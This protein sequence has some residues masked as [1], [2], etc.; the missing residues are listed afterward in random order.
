VQLFEAGETPEVVMILVGG[1]VGL[2]NPL[3]VDAPEPSSGSSSP[4]VRVTSVPTWFHLR[5][6]CPSDTTMV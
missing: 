6:G 3:I 5:Y 4:L 2:F 1:V